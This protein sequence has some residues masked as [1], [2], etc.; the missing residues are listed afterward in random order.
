M[1][2]LAGAM[3]SAG[4]QTIDKIAVNYSV[5]YERQH[6]F[7][8]K[9]SGLNVV[10]YDLEWPEIINYSGVAELKRYITHQLFG[11]QTA[12][13]DTAL[14][15]IDEKFGSPVT[16]Q[17]KTLPDDRRFCYANYTARL[18]SYSPNRWV[19]YQLDATIEPQALSAIRP[20]VVHQYFVYDLS[21]GEV[22]LPN[23][24]LSSAVVNRLEPQDFYD[25]LF[26]PL[27]DDDYDDMRQCDV[28]GVWTDSQNIFFHVVA[29]TSQ[30][31]VSYDVQMPYD[32]YS[33]VLSKRLRRLVE[34]TPK[35][36]FPVLNATVPTW[37]GDTIYNKVETMPV[38]KGGE[39]GQKQY[40]SHIDKPNV[41][42]G[43][44]VKVQMSYVVDRDGNVVDVCVHRPVTPEIDRHAAS[45]VRNMP[46]F[47]PGK[48][49]G[50]AVCVRMYV[51]LTYK[52]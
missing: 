6:L 32:R 48:Q 23:E 47:T 16:S 33:Y 18:L 24:L 13:L 50:R 8:Q 35:T 14:M 46:R 36:T 22:L 27:S 19:A 45:V 9:D 49:G 28:A 5:R 39:E 3:Q 43:R 15:S 41:N 25:N 42:L 10:D 1:L 4:A 2:F 11:F 34:K 40:L 38:F 7:L 29:T 44:P 31:T 37:R 20:L 30:R 17:F 21:R 26:A 51:P 12:S 52:P